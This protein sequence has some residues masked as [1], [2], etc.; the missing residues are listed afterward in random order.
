MATAK[1]K[2]AKKLT[3]RHKAV[4][5]PTKKQAQPN[6]T[7]VKK[8]ESRAMT[9]T[10][11]KKDVNQFEKDREQGL[12]RSH[13]PHS[14]AHSPAD[15]MNV[16]RSQTVPRDSKGRPAPDEDE[17]EIATP[18]TDEAM[19]KEGDPAEGH[20]SQRELAD[21]QIGGRIIAARDRR[22]YL[23]DQALKNEAAN[24]EV[25]AR[26]TDARNEARLRGAGVI[27][28][29]RM[30]EESLASSLADAEAHTEEGAEKRAQ[31]RKAIADARAERNDPSPVP[32]DISGGSGGGDRPENKGG[33]DK[34]QTDKAKQQAAADKA[35]AK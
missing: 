11:D 3:A 30:R 1:K 2:P 12:D 4:S 19:E 14:P 24:D 26:E 27:D 25:N 22:A 21:Q 7:K 32:G 34:N 9:A 6:R 29:D 16:N 5:K 23:I 28:P 33:S 10:D 35:A 13:S 31:S 20:L 17:E 15:K 18:L 8:K